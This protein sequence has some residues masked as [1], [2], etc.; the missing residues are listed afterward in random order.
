MIIKYSNSIPDIVRL[1]EH[2][3]STTKDGAIHKDLKLT[4]YKYYP[5]YTPSNAYNDLAL[6]KLTTPVAITV[7]IRLLIYL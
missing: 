1:G 2:D 7:C 3:T 4:E 5:E 6:I